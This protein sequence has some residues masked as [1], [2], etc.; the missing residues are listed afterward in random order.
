MPYCRT[1]YHDT[2]TSTSPPSTDHNDHDSS[3]ASSFTALCSAFSSSAASGPA[4][5]GVFL[6]PLVF[7]ALPLGVVAPSSAAP[8]RLP[9]PFGVAS[10]V[11]PAASRAFLSFDFSL[12]ILWHVSLSRYE[13]AVLFQAYHND[14]SFLRATFWES[15]VVPWDWTGFFDD[16]EVESDLVVLIGK[17]V[18]DGNSSH[19]LSVGPCLCGSLWFS[20]GRCSSWDTGS[21]CLI[22]IASGWLC[23]CQ[24]QF[25]EKDSGCKVGERRKAEGRQQKS[26]E[27]SC[28]RQV[29]MT[30][31]LAD[32]IVGEQ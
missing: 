14:T 4:L 8:L 23:C 10:T 18:V 29:R 2:D 15:D 21:I 3:S 9:L 25:K 7:F 12:S 24:I 31:L 22:V 1:P 13:I 19:L 6:P 11:S 16:L 26:A 28:E 32:A 17:S 5:T 27:E 20:H 30:Y